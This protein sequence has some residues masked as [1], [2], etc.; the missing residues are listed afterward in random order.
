[1][2]FIRLKRE[3]VLF[4]L[5][6]NSEQSQRAWKALRMNPPQTGNAY[7]QGQVAAGGGGTRLFL[8]VRRAISESTPGRPRTLR[9]L[10]LGP[11]PT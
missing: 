5:K 1:M 11:H 7:E 8:C 2:V 3:A 4:L 6:S 10:L 9:R